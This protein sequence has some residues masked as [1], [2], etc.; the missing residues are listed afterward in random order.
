MRNTT[1]IPLALPPYNLHIFKS[2]FFPEEFVLSLFFNKLP[3]IHCCLGKQTTLSKTAKGDL[4]KYYTNIFCIKSIAISK[5]FSNSYP[6]WI[7]SMSSRAVV[8]TT[9]PYPFSVHV[10]TISIRP[11]P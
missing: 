2:S 7:N 10:N 9:I 6:I 1:Q 8:C 5:T 11:V 4:R 3:K